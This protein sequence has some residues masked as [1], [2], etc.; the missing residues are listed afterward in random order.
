[1]KKN[2]IRHGRNGCH[3]AFTLI[4]LLVVIAIIAI[5]AAI[6]L[7]ALALAKEK[8]M[9]ISC[10]NN[11]KQMGL[12][13]SVYCTDNDDLMPPLK[14]RDGNAWYPYEM[15]R[16]SQVNVPV[17]GVNST[18]TSGPEN[19]G[20]L[21]YVKIAT[22]GK[23]FY[24]PS[25]QAKAD[26]NTYDYYNLNDPGKRC[27]WPWGSDPA[28][29]NP[30]YVRAGYS[31]YP[32]SKVLESFNT[33]SLGKKLIPVWPDYSKSPKPLSDWICVP[34]FKQTA[35]DQSKSMVVDIIYGDLKQMSHRF[36]TTPAGLNTCFGDGHVVWQNYKQNMGIG[37]GFDPTEWDAITGGSGGDLRYVLSVWRP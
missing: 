8:A 15:F 28:S 19:L 36:G 1:M 37:G 24:C 18:F 27:I 2:A 22:D 12:G 10:A 20:V 30:D 11:L 17:D 32:Q 9:R 21:W 33:A 5:L 4:E 16:Y 29:S 13:I 6:L 35:I 31:Y 25:R 23:A 7:P 3:R 34:P 26:A 14:W